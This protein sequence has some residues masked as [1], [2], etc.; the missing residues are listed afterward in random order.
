MS[1]EEVW[2]L[3]KTGLKCTAYSR[4]FIV[5][6]IF[7]CYVLAVVNSFWAKSFELCFTSAEY[8]FPLTRRDKK[9]VKK[10]PTKKKGE[11]ADKPV[12]VN[13]MKP[14]VRKVPKKWEW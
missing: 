2:T 8:F 4:Y 14:G 3:E 13:T 5:Y 9:P 10:K 6:L 1:R 7:V 11:L 12:K